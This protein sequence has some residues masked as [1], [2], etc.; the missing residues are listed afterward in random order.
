MTNRNKAKQEDTHFRILRLL[1]ENPNLTQRG[2]ADAVGISLGALNYCLNALM[3]KGLI[4]IR[5][6][7][8]SKHK[9]AYAYLLTP[10]GIGR[11]AELAARFL[12]RK[13]QE[14]EQLKAEI[15]AL[16]KFELPKSE[17]ATRPGAHFV[18][19]TR[20]ETFAASDVEAETNAGKASS[21][22]GRKYL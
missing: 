21:A 20:A 1:Q 10:S 17:T 18:E 2:L 12:S 19:V 9:L 4:K 22:T 3:D 6:F 13:L 5:S 7:R 8:S 11:K 16:Q 15:E 14:Y